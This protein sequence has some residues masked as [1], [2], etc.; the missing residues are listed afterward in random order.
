MEFDFNKLQRRIA[1]KFGTRGAFVI[2]ADYSLIQLALRL[3]NRLPF[4][5]DE[6]VRFSGPDLLDI[7]GEEID[8][9]FFTP[10]VR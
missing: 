9:Y 1:D 10:K 5:S 3:D 6:I 2:A 8:E 4:T 7:P